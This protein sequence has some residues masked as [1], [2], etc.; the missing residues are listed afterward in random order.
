[1]Q[2]VCISK[3][4]LFRGPGTDGYKKV[5]LP[6]DYS[7][8]LPRSPSAP[9]G[10]SN[11]YFQGGPGKYVKYHKFDSNDK[12]V[13]LDIDGAYMCASVRLNDQLLAMHP[14][15]YTPFLV[16]LTE[17]IHSGRTNKITVETNDMQPSTRWY[18][19]AGVYRDVFLWTGGPV[20][21]KPWDIFI[22]TPEVSDNEAKVIAS[23]QI[24]SNLDGEAILRGQIIDAEGKVVKEDETRITVKD[25]EKTP[26]QLSF[27]LSSPNLWDV[28]NPYLYS[29]HT[30][31]IVDNKCTD[32]S[33]TTFGIRTIYADA[34]KGF[35]LNGR[36]MKLRGGCIHHDHG[37]LGAAAFPAAEERK[38][39][40]LKEAG[41]NAIRIAHYPPSLALLEVCDRLG[42]LVMDEAFDMWRNGKNANDYHLW[43]EDWWARDISYMVLRD[44]N[45]PCVVSYSIGNEVIERDGSSDGA[46]WSA[47]LA[48]EVR[49]YDNTR[50][51]TSGICGM[52]TYPEE[53]D[54]EDYKE[55]FYQGY[56]DI[57]EGGI[58]TSWHKRT[59]D[60]M[61]P[62]DIVGYNYLY[63][64]Y[65]HDHK[66]Y[67]DRVI[68]GSETHALDFYDSWKAVLENDHVIGDFT[69][70]AYD[71]LGEVGT[72]RSCWERDGKITGIS[73]AEYPWRSCYQGDLDLCGYR[74]PQSYFREAVWIGNTQPRIFTVHPEHYGEGFSGTGWHWYDVLDSWTFDDK[75][76]GKMVEVQ[77]YTDA[78]E[79]VFFLNGQEMG[80]SR[81]VKGIATL[82]IP[83]EKGT[84]SVIAFKDG[85][86]CGSSSL[87]T[88]GKPAKVKVVPEKTVFNADN[89]DL[90]YFQIYI[91]DE[92]DDR[93][94]DAKNE[95]TC[96]VDGGELMGIFSGDPKNEDQYTSNK[97]H[98]FEGRALAIIRT[99]NPGEVKIA[100]GSPGLRM[101][102]CTVTA[103]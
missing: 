101:D 102:T 70:T 8:S 103:K 9:G 85:V 32:T 75:Y 97:C 81:T 45:H 76:V 19:G 50:L 55:I 79:V 5:D 80:R 73:I 3:D 78:D 24:A 11:G 4:W 27:T 42:M 53:C 33:D 2:K 100:V 91:T 21:I 25:G 72:G 10:G 86:E 6:H 26:A 61:K 89:R 43:F 40:L 95:L 12:Y 96:L 99:N 84:L 67:P 82:D 56:P 66:L 68:W 64:R 83:Y 57:G 44:R 65:E 54:P 34:K 39:R 28:D 93:V 15:G 1:M 94:P 46:K 7:I 14:Y 31:I 16:D 41:F 13:I 20:R 90:C 87:H 38:V 63:K 52:W 74:R 98:A 88:V 30:E 69:W 48:A 51:V 47:L 17:K 29:L 92:N 58:E 59:E 71:N 37:V 36:P 62:L 23:C 18:S 22:T 49:K 35:L 77:V 60:V